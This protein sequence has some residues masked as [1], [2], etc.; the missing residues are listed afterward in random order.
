MPSRL[1]NLKKHRVST[2]LCRHRDHGA[3]VRTA[4]GFVNENGFCYDF[5]EARTLSNG[6]CSIRLGE[7]A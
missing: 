3:A 1:R 6:W 5:R 7:V 4:S 2:A